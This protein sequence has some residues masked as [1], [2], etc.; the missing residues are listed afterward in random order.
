MRENRLR[1]ILNERR[2]T[3]GAFMDFPSPDIVE[4]AAWTGFEWIFMDAEHVGVS[5]ETCY[6]LVRAADAAGIASIVRVPDIR[7]ETILA[8]SDTGVSGITGPHIRTVAD[9]QAFVS[10]LRYGPRGIRG[11]SAGSRAANFGITQSPSEYFAAVDTHPVAMGLLEDIEAYDGDLEAIV[12][13][14]GLDVLCLGK[15]D[16]SISAGVPGDLTHPEVQTRVR[17]AAEVTHRRGKILNEAVGDM[18]S[19]ERALG[20]GTHMLMASVQG[21]LGQAATSFLGSVREAVDKS[22]A[23]PR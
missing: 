18:A 20:L 21:L 12:A 19:V 13:V 15:M 10:A 5:V 7:A 17:K 2:V 4:F 23:R 11:A 9:A 22:A 16:L 6:N 14:E 8:Y 1:K 3:V